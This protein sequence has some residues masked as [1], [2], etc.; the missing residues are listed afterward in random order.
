GVQTWGVR[1]G[2]EGEGGGVMGGEQDP[3]ERLVGDGIGPKGAHVPPGLDQAVE[4]LTFFGREAAAHDHPVYAR[5]AGFLANHGR[6]ASSCEPRWNSIAS[7]PK[8]ATSCTAIGRPWAWP[9]GSTMAG[10]PV[11]LNHTVNG[12][13][14][15]TR[16]QYSSKSSSIMSIQPSFGGS[17]ASPGVNSTS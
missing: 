8:P 13:K 16:R 10:W 11:R 3:L 6:A 7:S 9:S 1:I 2:D 5:A 12:E 17:V 14:W 15:K 4:G